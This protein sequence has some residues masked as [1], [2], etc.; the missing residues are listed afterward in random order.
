MK[1][2]KI[3]GFIAAS[4]FCVFFFL[5]ANAVHAF[6]SQPKKIIIPSID[7][8]L[9]VH[10]AKIIFDTWEVNL[11]GV[12]FGLSSALPGNRGNTVIFS[13]TI[14]RLFGRLDQIK[15]GDT[16]HIFTDL[17]WFTYK[18]VST[19]V[20]KPEETDILNP[21]NKFELTLYTCTKDPTYSKRFVVKAVLQENTSGSQ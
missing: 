14:D 3:I 15:K 9:D 7:I 18:V 8:A 10:P 13:H 12:S 11:D 21:H 5:Q 6:E 1:K 20:V 17:D 2:D 4:L 16:I 19:R